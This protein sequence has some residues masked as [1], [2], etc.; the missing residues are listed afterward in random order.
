MAELQSQPLLPEVAPAAP[1]HLKGRGAVH[2]REGCPVPAPSSS[3]DPAKSTQAPAS[4]LPLGRPS[5]SP[6]TSRKPPRS[7]SHTG[8]GQ[9]PQPARKS[10]PK[11]LCSIRKLEDFL[12][13]PRPKSE[14]R[15]GVAPC[16]PHELGSPAVMAGWGSGESGGG[17]S[18]HGGPASW[19]ASGKSEG[20]ALTCCESETAGRT[21]SIQPQ[22]RAALAPLPRGARSGMTTLL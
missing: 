20:P 1:S 6:S 17:S 18:P 9:H 21:R 16:S 8:Q 11:S 10:A 2:C 15:V 22:G 13:A 3:L 14:H 12:Q 19:R 4:P 7:G 5:G